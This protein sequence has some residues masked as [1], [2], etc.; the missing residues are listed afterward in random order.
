MDIYFTSN[1]A[2]LVN[3][4]AWTNFGGEVLN[5]EVIVTAGKG[6]LLL[7]GQLG[8]VMVESAKAAYSYLRANSKKLNLTK[9]FPSKIDIHVH[10]PA[11]ATPK[12]GPS[13]GVT[14]AVAL[15]SA[16]KNQIVAQNIAMTGEITLLGRVLAVGG[17]KEKVLAAYRYGIKKIFLP[18]A[19]IDD[20]EDIPA[21]IKKQIEFVAIENVLEV[22]E[23]I[24]G[25][26][27]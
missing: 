7:T 16:L 3:G 10:F 27:S 6:E 15:I 9:D 11:G 22:I 2:G 17:I 14:M 23:E 5:V 4:L 21:K 18:K 1:Q 19:N 8:D 20:L 12:D 13:A 24:F 26:E 25:G